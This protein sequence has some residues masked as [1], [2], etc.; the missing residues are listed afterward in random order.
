MCM[1]QGVM[2]MW[3]ECVACIKRMRILYYCWVLQDC[4]GG[5]LRNVS[6]SACSLASKC[7]LNCKACFCSWIAY[8]RSCASL[9][10]VGAL[11]C[12]GSWV[13]FIITHKGCAC[14]KRKRAKDD[15]PLLQCVRN[16]T[17]TDCSVFSRSSVRDMVMVTTNRFR[18]LGGSADAWLGQPSARLGISCKLMHS[19]GVHGCV[20]VIKI[21]QKEIFILVFFP[22]WLLCQCQ[23]HPRSLLPI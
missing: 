22:L 23:K 15:H 12:G 21:Q 1:W 13:L 2:W 8:Q 6:N 20:F 19:C 16:G 9:V 11:L 10:S 7:N 4:V 18:V 14:N 5:M 17:Q 3:C